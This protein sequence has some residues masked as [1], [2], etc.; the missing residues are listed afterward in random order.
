MHRQSLII[1]MQ[2]RRRS[3]KLDFPA[4][5]TILESR[6][7]IRP[8]ME[9]WDAGGAPLLGSDQEIVHA[10][11]DFLTAVAERSAEHAAPGQKKCGKV[12]SG[13][14]VSE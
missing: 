13:Q 11:Q 14:R 9:Q 5:S 6:Q 1:E 10:S 2:K 12:T 8:W 7:T 4:G 3:I